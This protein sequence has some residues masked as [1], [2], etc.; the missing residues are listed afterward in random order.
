M[1]RRVKS[2]AKLINGEYT[3]VDNMQNMLSGNEYVNILQGG[4]FV[5][6]NMRI[7]KSVAVL[8][9]H[10]DK[11][12]GTKQKLSKVSMKRELNLS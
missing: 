5:I 2:L 9:M 7:E 10:R 12:L 4:M 1:R 6:A 3:A 11:K 8:P